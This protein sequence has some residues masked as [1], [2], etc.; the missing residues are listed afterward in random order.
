MP[1]GPAGASH[2]I[3]LFDKNRLNKLYTPS[4]KDHFLH[5]RQF[6]CHNFISN[7]EYVQ[8]IIRFFNYHQHYLLSKYKI[9][10]NYLSDNIT[11]GLILRSKIK[12][13]STLDF[14]FFCRTELNHY[15]Q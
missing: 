9:N 2:I 11:Q 6:Q 14:F 13:I 15:F 5:E 1:L 7:K 10:L 12:G 8:E 4:L 3:I